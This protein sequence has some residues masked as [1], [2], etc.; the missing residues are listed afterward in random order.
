MKVGLVQNNSNMA[1][2]GITTPKIIK[3]SVRHLNANMADKP[4]RGKV[5]AVDRFYEM[6]KPFKG[7]RWYC[8]ST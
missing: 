7:N 4:L 2:K 5:D 1:M 3:K 8:Y 6:V